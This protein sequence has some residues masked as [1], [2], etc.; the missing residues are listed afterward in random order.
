MQAD[1]QW[2]RRTDSHDA[3]TVMRLLDAFSDIGG[4]VNGDTLATLLRERTGQ[5][6]SLLA[7]WIV[8]RRVLSFSWHSQT[9][10]PLFQFDLALPQVR[11]G[12]LQL[13]AEL[14]GVFDDLELADWFARPNSWLGDIAPARLY[15]DNFPAVLHAARADRFVAL[16]H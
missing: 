14:R 11:P 15:V 4:V 8:H 9:F 10:L 1:L 5:P 6:I 7:G 13:M 3:H 2:R 16:G 12:V